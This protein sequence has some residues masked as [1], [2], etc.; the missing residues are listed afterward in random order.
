MPIDDDDDV[1]LTGG[2]FFFDIIEE[3]GFQER[4]VE[5]IR[6][7]R[8]C[9]HTSHVWATLTKYMG[10]ETMKFPTDMWSMQEILF[11]TKPDVLIETGTWKGGSALYYA[12]IMDAIGKGSVLTID[13]D[14]KEN[15]PKHERIFYL[16]GDC[17]SDKVFKAVEGSIGWNE[18]VMV[19]LDSSHDKDHV[20]KEMELYGPLVTDGNYMVVEDGILGHP[21]NMKDRNGKLMFPGPYEAINEF[22]SC[23]PEFKADRDREKFQVIQNVKGYLRKKGKDDV[24]PLPLQH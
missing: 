10:I 19:D 12:H 21:V 5:L 17:L 6:D 16:E 22:L 15:L 2:K 4:I 11:E 9:Y 18:N 7:A 8:W 24:H 23:H 20:L 3:N 14:K 13:N 1:C